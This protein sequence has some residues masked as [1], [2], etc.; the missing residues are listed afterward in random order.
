MRE[1]ARRIVAA[2]IEQHGPHAVHELLEDVGSWWGED[3]DDASA[4]RQLVEQLLDGRIV[5]V[6]DDHAPRLL[7]APHE[8]TWLSELA[9][10]P[11]LDCSRSLR[12]A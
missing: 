6:T 2:V 11:L 3:D 12:N 8:P 10:R 4:A 1:E 5:L 7:D 9:D